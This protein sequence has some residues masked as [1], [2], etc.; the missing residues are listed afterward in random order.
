MDLHEQLAQ[1]S[2]RI[3]KDPID[4]TKIQGFEEGTPPPPEFEPR[5]PVDL[6]Q[7][8]EGPP[9]EYID[10]DPDFEPESPLIPRTSQTPVPEFQQNLPQAPADLPKPDFSIIGVEGVGY[11][12]EYL[13]RKVELSPSEVARAQNLVREAISRTLRAELAAL[14]PKRQRAKRRPRE[15][16]GAT[17]HTES[18]PTYNQSGAGVLPGTVSAEVGVNDSPGPQPA[19]SPKK[20]RKKRERLDGT[21]K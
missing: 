9:D 4:G 17:L 6:S 7:V 11:A 13:G 3:G 12:A 1:F 10:E 18:A 2:A 20:P 21:V 19:S 15:I 14:R 5:P 8:P 16:G